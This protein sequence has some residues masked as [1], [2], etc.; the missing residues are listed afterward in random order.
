MIM[1]KDIIPLWIPFLFFSM[2]IGYTQNNDPR[3]EGQYM[4]YTTQNM[5]ESPSAGAFNAV[6]EIDVNPAKGIPSINIPLYT[7][8]LD[9]VQVPISL[10]YD[11]SGIKVSQMSTAVGL[12]WSLVAGGQISR[13]V[14][15]KPDEENYNGWFS[16]GY[17]SADYYVGKN[18][19]DKFWQDEMKGTT[20]NA[21]KGL[22]NRRDHNPDLFSYSLLGYNGSYIHDT[23][24]SI[25][26][27][28]EDGLAI[29]PFNFSDDNLDARDLEG[30]YYYFDYGDTER[31]SN[32]NTFHTTSDLSEQFYEWENSNGLPIVT[33]WKLSN[34]TSKNGKV[35]EFAYESVDM[36]YIV[37]NESLQITLG[38][39]CHL[40]PDGLNKI[41]SIS[42]TNVNHRFSTQL[43]T[44]ISSPHSNIK[45]TFEYEDDNGLPDSVWKRKLK[46]ITVLDV[47]TGNKR[48][49]HFEYSRFSGD[50]RLKLER[51]QEKAFKNG[52][53]KAKPPHVFNYESGNLPPKD[54]KAQDLYGYYNLATNNESLVSDFFSPI[55]DSSFQGFFDQE[56]GNRALNING[57][58]RGVL[59]DIT[60]PTGGKTI[61]KYEPNVD[62]LLTLKGYRGG[63]RVKEIE[64]VDENN[65]RASRRTY[66]YSDLKGIDLKAQIYQWFSK[67]EGNTRTYSSSP[68]RIP[69][70]LEGYR[71]GFFYGKVTMVSHG[72]TTGEN[73]KVEYKYKDNPYNI[74]GFEHVLESET[75]FQGTTASRLKVVEYEYDIISSSGDPHVVEWNVVGDMDCYQPN[76]SKKN[77]GYT[78]TPRTVKFS[79][80]Y[81]YLP[82]RIA[83]TEFPSG[84]ASKRLTV[85]KDITYD[86]LTML[87]KTEITDFRYKREEN[88]SGTVSYTMS[89]PNAEVI[90]MIYTYPFDVPDFA[91][92]PS[93][94]QG[95]V[96]KQEVTTAKN[97][98][99]AQTGG[100]AYAFDSQGNIET[101]YSFEMGQGSN[102]SSL[103]YVP[104]HYQE[105]TRF[106]FSDGHPVQVRPKDGIPT[107]YIWNLTANVPV[108]KI[109]GLSRA[110]LNQNLVAQLEQADFAQLPSLLMQLRTTLPNPDKVFLTTYTYKPLAGVETITDP[111]GYKTTYEYDAF[112][113]L[114]YVRDPDGN[115]LNETEYNYALD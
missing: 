48:E 83:T 26:K 113:R 64:N 78:T 63:L 27:E 107:S 50:P 58:K 81:A 99:T 11:A 68:V 105:R 21:Y 8:E 62:N 31:S 10:S 72:A 15:S 77:I 35:I 97:G 16:A 112:G 74:Q 65:V 56:S 5:P 33:A 4:D 96:I 71:T 115:L 89:D 91:S 94:P 7:Y 24:G 36:E 59:T 41:S 111:K 93:F 3:N 110:A 39:R 43:L 92:L 46:K 79:G 95:T 109:E 102:Y 114:Q 23:N 98:Q 13:T 51:V 2:G 47:V 52:V 12:G 40:D 70:D 82:V 29:T 28:K 100:R 60:Y 90:T 88:S 22:V 57:L 25:I 14:R 6:G 73:F 108:A 37:A 49:F 44:E 80:N 32:E 103:S 85:L 87:K 17:I 67:L 38:N 61:F 54:S 9:G 53:A 66:Q 1:R 101:V 42:A 34:I 106:L 45:V 84:N 20:I 76:S 19:N 18:A 69:G 104:S 86:P 55:H 30:N 75:I